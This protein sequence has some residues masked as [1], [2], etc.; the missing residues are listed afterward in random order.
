MPR[1]TLCVALLFAA[2]LSGCG[3]ADE[4]AA[5]PPAR[6]AQAHNDFALTFTKTLFRRDYASASAMLAR[7]YA[8]EVAVAQLKSDFDALVSRSATGLRAEAIGE[9]LT[10]WPDRAPDETAI[11]YVSI[12]GTGLDEFDEPTAIS[13]TLGEEAGQQKVFGIEYGR[14]D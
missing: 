9:P 8:A 11:I 13:L 12:E 2:A 6:S 14:A 3:N 1:L 5:R 7:P 10:D 4:S